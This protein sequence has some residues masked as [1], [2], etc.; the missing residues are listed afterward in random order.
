MDKDVVY[1]NWWSK[2]LFKRNFEN[3]HY[4]PLPARWSD[5]L[6]LK[7]I[8]RLAFNGSFK[9]IRI[10]KPVFI[11]GLPRSGTTLLYNLLCSHERSAYIT[12]S[13]NSFT[14]APC[15]IEWLRK[16]FKLN[17]RGPRFLAD[18]IDTDFGSPSEPIMFWGKWFGRDADSLHWEERRGAE[19]APAEVEAMRR[20]IRKILYCFGGSSQRLVIKYPVMQTELLMLQDLFPDARFIHILRDGRDVAHSLI[21]LYRLSNEQLR[22]IKHPTVSHIVPY[23]RVAGLKGYIDRFG[24][25]S[26][27]CTSRVWSEA[28]ELVEEARPKLTN[29]LEVRHEK[30]LESPVSNLE[31]IFEFCDLPWPKSPEFKRT[32]DSIGKI[33][34]KNNYAGN[35]IVERAVGPALEKWGY[36]SI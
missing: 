2:A 31:K 18:S 5:R 25:E 29:F 28:L 24:A 1:A 34:H 22:K 36:G 32:F 16:K 12:N 7:T 17:I 11:V 14:E 26:L 4:I 27:E 21:K 8:E 23:P 20:D 10:E 3:Q 30:I 19:L 35:E 6:L 33:S 9:D 13:M 15:A